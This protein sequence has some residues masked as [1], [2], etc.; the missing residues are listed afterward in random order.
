MTSFVYHPLLVAGARLFLAIASLAGTTSQAG[1]LP[2]LRA[3]AT[4][5]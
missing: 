4:T 5:R 1:F 3:I 2:L